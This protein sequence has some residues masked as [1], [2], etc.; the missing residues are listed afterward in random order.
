MSALPPG[1][2]VAEIGDVTLPFE[3][4]NPKL[5][6]DTWFSYIDIGC[7]D[8]STQKI[9]SAKRFR[10]RDAPSRARRIARSGDILFSTVRTHLRNIALVS[11]EHDE[12]LVSTGIALLRPAAGMDENYLFRYVCSQTFVDEVSRSQDGTVYP[13]VR[14]SDVRSTTIRVPP[15]EEQGRIA[16]ALDAIFA[17]LEIVREEIER[18]SELLGRYRRAV[19]VGS[20]I[21]D[22]DAEEAG[23]LLLRSDDYSQAA[24]QIS[25]LVPAHWSIARLGEIAQIQTGLAL[26]RD[27]GLGSRWWMYPICAWRM[28]NGDTW[29]WRKSRR[30][31]LQ[32]RR[33]NC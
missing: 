4:I 23:A 7:I 26:V 12:H 33:L 15:S 3:T 10:G 19:V 24:E 32:P 13:A 9:R 6:P 20:L 16:R 17:R 8:N 25:A 31:R 2:I 5:W 30:F 21:G 11:T 1:W 18:V 28:S 27:G 29:R 14:E 22:F